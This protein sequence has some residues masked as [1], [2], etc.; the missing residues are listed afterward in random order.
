VLLVD[1]YCSKIKQISLSNNPSVRPE[2][3]GRPFDWLMS[4]T[5]KAD[6]THFVSARQ[7]VRH[8]REHPVR[9]GLEAQW[10][11]TAPQVGSILGLVNSA[12]SR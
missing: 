8:L 6:R 2:M 9:G 1:E 12:L 10:S 4:R 7:M 11:E 5:S 3:S